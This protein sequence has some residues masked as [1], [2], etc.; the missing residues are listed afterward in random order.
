MN[1][2]LYFPPHSYRPPRAL[3]G[4]VFGLIRRYLEQNSMRL[5]YIEIEKIFHHLIARGHPTST[6]RPLFQDADTLLDQ[7]ANGKRIT[8][9]TSGKGKRNFFHCQFRPNEISCRTMRNIYKQKCN[10]PTSAQYNATGIPLSTALGTS[11]T[12]INQVKIS[13]LR[14]PNLRGLFASLRLH[15]ASEREVY[16]TLSLFYHVHSCERS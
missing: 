5:D 9:P 16:L 4:F 14:P 13:Y 1:L 12:R 11:G 10:A 8:I 7:E 2:Y 3:Q 15:K 6:L